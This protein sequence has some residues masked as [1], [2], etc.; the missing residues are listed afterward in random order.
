MDLFGK[1]GTAFKQ[2]RSSCFV[3]LLGSIILAQ[4]ACPSTGHQI[5]AASHANRDFSRQRE[6]ALMK[7]ALQ[8]GEAS[9]A[10]RIRPFSLS[11][12]EI[13]AKKLSY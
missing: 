8:Q 4:P 7:L 1:N 9:L 5:H 6:I 10:V 11:C 2:I 12:M 13:Y 3:F